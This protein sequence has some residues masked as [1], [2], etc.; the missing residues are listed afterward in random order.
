MYTPE[1][2]KQHV[3][4]ARTTLYQRQK[5]LLCITWLPVEGAGQ[6]RPTRL[7]CAAWALEVNAGHTRIGHCAQRSSSRVWLC[8]YCSLILGA[9]KND[10]SFLIIWGGVAHD[11][12]LQLQNLFLVCRNYVQ[13]NIVIINLGHIFSFKYGYMCSKQTDKIYYNRRH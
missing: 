3:G 1:D 5:R 13:T 11:T 10:I 4:H 6:S 12:R 2:R 9:L 7:P 8:Y